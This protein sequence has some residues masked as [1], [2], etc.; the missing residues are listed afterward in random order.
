M[1]LRILRTAKDGDIEES[2]NK[3]S[4]LFVSFFWLA[5]LGSYFFKIFFACEEWAHG[6]LG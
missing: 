1:T 4:F 6:T 3:A 2:D 5:M